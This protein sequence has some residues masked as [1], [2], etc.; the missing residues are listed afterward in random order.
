MSERLNEPVSK[1]GVLFIEYRGFES[2]P[3]RCV[4]SLR[5]W[6]ENPRGAKHHLRG[7]DTPRASREANPVL[8]VVL[9]YLSV[10][11]QI[12]FTKQ[13]SVK[14]HCLVREDLRSSL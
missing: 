11:R 2:R 12:F 8:S 1:T 10:L 3:L 4:A 5:W 6:D 9:A 7:F 13:A 14:N